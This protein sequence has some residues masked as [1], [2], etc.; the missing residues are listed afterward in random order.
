MTANFQPS[1]FACR[2]CGRG[3]EIVKPKLIAALQWVRNDWGR[4]MAVTSGYRCPKHNAEV[5]GAKS[6]AHVFGEAADIADADGALRA[7]MTED[8]LAIYGL[9]AED[10]WATPGW[11]HMQIRPAHH[12]IF[13]P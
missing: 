9:W 12:R 11:L 10:Y 7:W 6:S 3:A 2:C 8:M 4:P 1:E 5:G 13:V